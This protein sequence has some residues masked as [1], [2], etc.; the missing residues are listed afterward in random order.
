VR[1]LLLMPILLSLTGCPAA[2]PLVAD[3]PM[4]LSAGG[5]GG[6]NVTSTTR[7]VLSRPNFRLIRANAIGESTGFKLLGLLTFKSPEYAEAITRLYRQAGISGGRPQTFV[8]VVYDQTS[9]F[10]LLFSLPKIT[11]RGD[12]VEF[13]DERAVRPQSVR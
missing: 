13:L 9:T 12:L 4:G 2:F 1:V 11:V 5:G 10:F 7:V 8:N 6:T 3:L